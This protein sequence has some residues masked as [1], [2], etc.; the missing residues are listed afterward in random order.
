MKFKILS[1]VAATALLVSCGS[2]RYNSSSHPAYNVP[3][4]IATTFD[5]QYPTATNVVWTT[6]DPAVAIPIDWE[7]TDWSTLDEQDYMATFDMGSDKMY[8]WFDA[9]GAWVGTTYAISNFSS[10]PSAINA[11]LK[12]KYPNYTIESVQRE[13]WREKNAYE[14][15]LKSGDTKSKVLVDMNGNIIKQKDKY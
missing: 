11:T 12:D 10:L 15:K 8:A 6:Y 7:L 2:T 1:M 13:M 3:T 4:A 5:A 9:N 14:I